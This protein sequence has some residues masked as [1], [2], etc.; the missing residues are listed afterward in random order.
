MYVVKNKI[1]GKFIGRWGETDDLSKARQ[2]SS[3]GHP[4]TS[5]Y[6]RPDKFDV[7]PPPQRPQGYYGY[8]RNEAA[9]AI[10]RKFHN[11]MEIWDQERL[12]LRRVA[13]DKKFEIIKVSVSVEVKTL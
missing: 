3:V 1:T 8:P 12:R 13:W 11:D 5:P 2:F 6:I 7:P 4:K 10:Q 9:E